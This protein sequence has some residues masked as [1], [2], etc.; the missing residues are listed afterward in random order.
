MLD[1][2]ANV[3]FSIII[4]ALSIYTINLRISRKRI[5]ASLAKTIFD[6]ETLKTEL[7]K[8]LAASESKGLE[9]SEGFL[10]FVSD[11][12]EWAFTYIE[13][14]QTKLKSFDKVASPILKQKD[15]S[16]DKI[17]KLSEA[18]KDLESLLP[19]DDK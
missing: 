19:K 3:I 2:I 18:Y 12:R 1:I 11:S 7:E 8:A 4:A 13:D 16:L 14:V 6:Q 9:Q 5:A 15:I 17:T 10:K